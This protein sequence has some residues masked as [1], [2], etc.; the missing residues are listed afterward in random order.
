MTVATSNELKRCGVP[1]HILGYQYAGYAI[2]LALADPAII[3]QM[4]KRLYPEVARHFGTT[5]SRVERA[6]RHAVE[7]SFY[8]MPTDIYREMFGNTVRLDKG[9]ATNSQ[10]IATLAECIKN[11]EAN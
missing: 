4:V 10:F 5:P 11:R 2:D 7:A 9:K 3:N 8:N 1:A 6:I